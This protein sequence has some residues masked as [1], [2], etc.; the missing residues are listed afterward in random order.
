MGH[1]LDGSGAVAKD[2]EEQLAAFAE[3]VEPAAEGDG[4]AFVLAES[5]DGGDG[6][7]CG[8]GGGFFGHDVCAFLKA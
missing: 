1:A 5:G 7:G 6:G 4:L 2:G 8:C 3:V